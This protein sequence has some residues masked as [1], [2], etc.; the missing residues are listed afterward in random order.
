[1]PDLPAGRK[2]WLPE[3]S[4]SMKEASVR[5]RRIGAR[6]TCLFLIVHGVIELTGLF[7]PDSIAHNLQSF[8]GMDKP[9]NETKEAP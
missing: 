7:A 9:G 5:L 2:L 8:G 4:T 6:T 3:M 1:M